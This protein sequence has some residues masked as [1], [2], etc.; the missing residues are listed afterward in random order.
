MVL[1]LVGRRTK[2]CQRCLTTLCTIQWQNLMFGA[3]PH[4]WNH[5]LQPPNQQMENLSA[6]RCPP[7]APAPTLTLRTSLSFPSPASHIPQLK[8]NQWCPRVLRAGWHKADL[9]CR[10]SPDQACRNP[11]PPNPETT[12]TAANSP[13]NSSPL[14]DLACRSLT[15]TVRKKILS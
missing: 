13:A 14:P 5:C 12:E 1:C 3:T 11:R 4:L 8:R 10:P 7:H 9:L 6:P 15:K 2:R